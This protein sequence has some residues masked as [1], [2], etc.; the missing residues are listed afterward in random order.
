MK[1]KKNKGFTLIE[2][3]VVIAI[4]GILASMLLPVLAKAKIKTN[5]LK[6]MNNIKNGGGSALQAY[7]VEFEGFPWHFGGINNN[8]YKAQ[9][10][11]EWRDTFRLGYIWGANAMKSD[12]GN[13]R[14]LASPSDPAVVT[15]NKGTKKYATSDYSWGQLAIWHQT[16]S[17]AIC[18]GGDD[19]APETILMTTRNWVGDGGANRKAYWKKYGG[20]NHNDKWEFNRGEVKPNQMWGNANWKTNNK[21]NKWGKKLDPIANRWLADG[22]VDPLKG[23]TSKSV[24]QVRM[25]SLMRGQGTVLLSDQSVRQVSGNVEL[26]GLLDKHKAADGGRAVQPGSLTFLRPWQKVN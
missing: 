13:I 6:C 11:R 19:L 5:R 26:E 14:M 10:Y 12:L 18:L 2:L 21:N 16:Q 7:A 24:R 9:G 23:A 4:I 1:L 17:Y 8:E 20:K 22:F 25:N 15:K 3:L